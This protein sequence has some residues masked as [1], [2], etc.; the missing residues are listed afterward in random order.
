MFVYFPVNG[1]L[2]Y[3]QFGAVM[4]T[5]LMNILVQMDIFFISFK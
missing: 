3:F 5:F 1:H 2:A 4:K